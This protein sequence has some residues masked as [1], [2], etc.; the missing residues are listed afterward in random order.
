MKKKKRMR[1]ERERGWKNCMQEDK[2][3]DKER[4]RSKKANEERLKK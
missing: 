4:M 1:E 2:E 3:Q